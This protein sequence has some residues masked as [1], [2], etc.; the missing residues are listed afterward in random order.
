[1]QRKVFL[2]IQTPGMSKEKVLTIPPALDH[3]SRLNLPLTGCSS[4]EPAS[5]SVQHRK[6][7]LNNLYLQSVKILSHLPA[8]LNLI[9][10]VRLSMYYHF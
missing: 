10:T 7:Q 3:S 1:M 9:N 2:G 8:E 5:V 4:A 6:I